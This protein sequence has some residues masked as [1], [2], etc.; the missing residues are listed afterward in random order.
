[1]LDKKIENSF[2]T[3]VLFV[4]KLAQCPRLLILGDVGGHIW[5]FE[6]MGSDK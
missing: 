2:K 4:F 5:T 1:M 3:M 6:M